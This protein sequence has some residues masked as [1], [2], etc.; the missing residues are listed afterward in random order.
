MKL[1]LIYSSATAA[2]LNCPIEEEQLQRLN[3]EPDASIVVHDRIDPITP[4]PRLLGYCPAISYDR[5]RLPTFMFGSRPRS[6]LAR[7]EKAQL[8]GLSSVLHSLARRLL[9]DERLGCS[10]TTS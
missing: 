1:T 8:F 10:I 2:M 4:R 3:G 7:R 5:V 9:S 6:C